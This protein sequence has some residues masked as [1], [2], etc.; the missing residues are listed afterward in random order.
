MRD[1][2]VGGNLVVSDR[3]VLTIDQDAA[4]DAVQAGQNRIME[5]M[6]SADWAQRRADQ[7]SPMSFPVA[8]A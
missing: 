3:K 8:E 2:Y 5:R 1:V 6:P 4:L 7:I